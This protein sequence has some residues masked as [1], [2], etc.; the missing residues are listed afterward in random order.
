MPSLGRYLTDYPE[1]L[2]ELVGKAMAKSPEE[3]FQTAEDFGYELARLQET[4]KRGMTQEFLSKARMAIERKDWDLA[5]QQLQEV[6]RFERRNSE[7]NELFHIV[8]QEIQRQQRSI[9]IA[10]LRSQAQMALTGLHY[11][12]AME[13]IELARRLDPDDREL[14]ALSDSIT[15]Q[16]ERAKELANA[17]RRGQ[18][19][20]Y[21]GDLNEAAAAVKKALEIDQN[22]TE[23]K[24]L[25]SL[26][27]KELEERKRRA[28]LQ[29]FVEEARREI[30]SHNFLSAL[31]SLQKAQAIDPA[32][33]NIRELLNWAARGHEQE[34]LR[35]ALQKH[36]NEIGQLLGEDR[37]VEAL[38]A[39]RAALINFPNDPSLQQLLQLAE[40]QLDLIAR[41]REIDEAC[42]HARQLMDS[43]RHADAIRLLEQALSSFP[44][45]PNLETLLAITRSE[46]ERR[47]REKEDRERQHHV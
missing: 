31:H 14:I 3:R 32:D 12:E 46:A 27:K 1:G 47:E 5:R 39:C 4:I 13:C 42:A 30:S 45:E 33:S 35:N 36:T 20:L 38:E 23:A 37:Y 8:R 22:H 41:R 28:Q 10:Q 11:E 19:A 17:L 34:K 25:E 40:R 16:V 6:L 18:A 9:Q 21:A 7:A 26:I 44:N 43:D 2:D 24:A 29:D 15:I